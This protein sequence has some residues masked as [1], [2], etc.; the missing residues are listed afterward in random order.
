MTYYLRINGSTLTGGPRA[1]F[2]LAEAIKFF[3]FNVNIIYD[4]HRAAKVFST[5]QNDYLR[6]SNYLLKDEILSLSSNDVV[7]LSETDLWEIDT[8]H[9]QGLRIWIYM[10]SV[11]NGISY[12][13]SPI[14][15][16]G[17]LRFLKNV[18]K[19]LP[20]SFNYRWT[21]IES[22]ISLILTQS[23]YAN[24]AIQRSG[25]MI[26]Y[27]YIGDFI[28]F[29][30]EA[31]MPNR[32]ISLTPRV[33]YNPKK[34]LFLFYLARLFNPKLI[35]KPIRGVDPDN[36]KEFM[37]SADVYV[38]FGGQPG[39]DRLPREALLFGLP[40]LLF[41]RGAA[42]N[43]SDFP[44]VGISFLALWEVIFLNRRIKSYLLLVAGN[45]DILR[46]QRFN[47]NTEREVFYSRVKQVL[48]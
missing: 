9:S 28:S 1:I 12:G 36:M 8:W 37:R 19:N 5:W 13:V 38:D 16:E 35:F 43:A 44:G 45:I 6:N 34:G 24:E 42:S 47:I 20:N 11:D 29:K 31:P 40:V 3:D 33:V 7:V 30:G 17:R 27:Y 4:S 48:G 22:K 46:A 23:F 14:T 10:L 15:F 21:Q 18:L 41:R 39:K 25:R 32:G 26:P 2:Q